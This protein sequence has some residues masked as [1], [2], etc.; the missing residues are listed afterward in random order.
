MRYTYL[1]LL[2]VTTSIHASPQVECNDR[3]ECWPQGSAMHQVL[4]LDNKLTT[5]ESR[6]DRAVDQLESELESNK[7][8]DDL[9]ESY[10]H[11][12]SILREAQNAWSKYT[13]AEC[14]FLGALSQTGGSWPHA[15]SARCMV[16]HNEARLK[17]L[18]QAKRCVVRVRKDP[19]QYDPL[20]CL[21]QLAPLTNG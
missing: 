20:S 14:T 9:T 7:R 11:I 19:A 8:E 18:Q 17:R 4:S 5:L 3:P 16:N 1:F 10:L 6:I 2:L 13:I 12:T 21:Q 15:R